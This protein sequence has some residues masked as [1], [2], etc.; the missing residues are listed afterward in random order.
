VIGMMEISEK[1]FEIL[2]MATLVFLRDLGVMPTIRYQVIGTI[3]K[4]D[5]TPRAIALSDSPSK[6]K[7]FPVSPRREDDYQLGMLVTHTPDERIIDEIRNPKSEG[8]APYKVRAC[9][10]S[11]EGDR[12]TPAGV[13][14]SPHLDRYFSRVRWLTLADLDEV[15]RVEWYDIRQ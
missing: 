6:D 1:K 10:G 8:V 7:A 2:S 9:L 15:T 3:R 13:I 4:S 12:S 11:V 5:G 14:V